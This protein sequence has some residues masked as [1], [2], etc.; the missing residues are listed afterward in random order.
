MEMM[1]KAMMVTTNLNGDSPSKQSYERSSIS[2]SKIALD[3]KDGMLGEIRKA[4]HQSIGGRIIGDNE[5]KLAAT[6]EENIALT[7]VYNDKVREKDKAFFKYAEAQ[8][9]YLEI[10]RNLTR[11]R[12]NF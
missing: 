7:K 6:L 3:V 4:I 2:P 11:F 12:K 8:G 10:M 1:K 5:L 9:Q